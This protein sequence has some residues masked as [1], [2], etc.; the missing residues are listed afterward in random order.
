MGD[1]NADFES[2]RRSIRVGLNLAL[3]GFSYWTADV[4]GLSGETT[5]ETHIRYA[6]WALLSP[7]ARYFVR[8]EKIDK[9]RFPW[10]HNAQVEFNFR[11]YAELRMRLLPY[12]NTLAHESHLT[13]IPIMRPLMLEFP[14]DARLRQRG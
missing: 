14:E 12:Y 6:Q 8:P 1:Q 7:V 10:S 9:T 3:A 4:F 13:G 11:R 2:I 5:P